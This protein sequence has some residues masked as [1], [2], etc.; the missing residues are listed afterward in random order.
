MFISCVLYEIFWN[1]I[2]TV[3]KH[4]CH[5]YIGKIFSQSGIVYCSYK[6]FIADIYLI[7]EKKKKK[8][9]SMQHEFTSCILV[10]PF[11]FGSQ[12]NVL[13]FTHAACTND[14][15]IWIDDYSCTHVYRGLLNCDVIGVIIWKDRED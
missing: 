5:D 10:Q 8:E 1:F 14:D 15:S 13:K 3:M 2:G 12:S 7:K 11:S 6:I 4:Y 9:M